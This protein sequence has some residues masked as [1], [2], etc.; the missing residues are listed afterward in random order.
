MNEGA[1]CRWAG[2]RARERARKATSVRGC[3]CAGVLLAG[4]A[5]F[6]CK[7]MCLQAC[8]CLHAHRHPWVCGA[9]ASFRALC[10]CLTE[11]KGRHRACTCR[12]GC[13]FVVFACRCVLLRCVDYVAFSLCSDVLPWAQ[14]FARV[15]VGVRVSLGACVAFALK[16]A[17]ML[18]L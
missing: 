14:F 10:P 9:A 1:G 7:L 12:I 17:G 6:V 13:V 3:M 5:R 16:F 2:G 15:C 8:V 11:G 4:T 18:F